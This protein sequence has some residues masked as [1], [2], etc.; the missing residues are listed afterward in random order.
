VHS[1]QVVKTGWSALLNV[2]A[3]DGS[4]GWTQRIGSQPDSVREENVQLYGVG[5]FLQVPLLLCQKPPLWFKA[6]QTGPVCN[7]V[8][9]VAQNCS[10]LALSATCEIL[11]LKTAQ[12]HPCLQ[13]IK[14]LKLICICC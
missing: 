3:E 1:A 14:L 11:R 4:I 10:K 12:N 5:G 9:A 2:Q 8:H 6:A 7:P 13:P